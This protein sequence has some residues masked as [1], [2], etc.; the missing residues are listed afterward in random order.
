MCCTRNSLANYSALSCSTSAQS[1]PGD[2]Q[3]FTGHD[4]STNLSD[5]PVYQMGVDH[6]I[7]ANRRLRLWTSA[8]SGRVGID[9]QLLGRLM[10]HQVPRGILPR[11]IVW[12]CQRGF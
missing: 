10:R 4:T 1:D 3:V 2:C 9:S 8:K 11:S 7:V 12:D 6:T 5:N